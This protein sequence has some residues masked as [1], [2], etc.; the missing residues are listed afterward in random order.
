MFRSQDNVDFWVFVKST[1]FK[2]C[3]VIIGVALNNRSYTYVYFFW[4]LHTIKM[5]F[6]R[7]PVCYMTNISNM[8]SA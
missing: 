5:K 2:I 4:I 6:G 7:M 1:Y 8:F 3:D